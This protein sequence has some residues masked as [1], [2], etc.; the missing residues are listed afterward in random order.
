MYV[1][2]HTDFPFY[3]NSMLFIK[4][5]CSGQVVIMLGSKKRRASIG[6]LNNERELVIPMFVVSDILEKIDMPEERNRVKAALAAIKSLGNARK[7]GE[8][9]ITAYLVGGAVRDLIIDQPIKDV[10]IEVHGLT[11]DELDETLKSFGHLNCVGKSFGVLRWEHSVV[12]WAVPRRDFAGRKP[13][14]EINPAM[15]I[16]DALRRRDLTVNAMAI[17][18]FSGELIDPFGG[19]ADLKNKIARSPD[20][21]FFADDPL[22]FYRVMQFIGRFELIPDD[23]LNKTCAAM[24][25]ADV[26]HER[27]YGEFDK[28][29]LKSH[30]P[31][32]GIRWLDRINRLAD[33]LPE[34]MPTVGLMQNPKWHPEGDVF[35]HT[36]QVLDAAA[37]L[38]YK[39]TE[40]KLTLLSAALCHD[41][42]KPVATY[43]DNGRIR[44]TDHAEKGEPLVHS[45]IKRLTGS[46]KRIAAVCKLVKYHMEPG[47]FVENNASAKAYRRLAVKLAPEAS[48]HTLSLLSQAD[49]R[50]RN[51]DRNQ[52]LARLIDADTSVFIARAR[53]LGVYEAPEAPVLTGQDLL[54]VIPEGT[55]LGTA[56]KR[57]YEIQIGEG[58]TDKKILKKRVLAELGLYH[59]EGTKQQ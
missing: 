20:I 30:A 56:V 47:S 49:K 46:K 9:A 19:L 8:A 54:D 29:F 45:M 53:E 52:P 33:V 10:D 50:G 41:L 40:E 23:E 35:E 7:K 2:Y 57:A 3:C 14:V 6:S 28:L 21:R 17:D 55:V 34:L 25:I 38:D 39:T 11:L 36:M 48:L 5:L 16:T 18:L 27:I 59:E 51:P 13:V 24:D 12:D 15:N 4:I 43:V 26:S 32:R 22:R 31:A 1:V 42:G 44:S 37:T 58:I